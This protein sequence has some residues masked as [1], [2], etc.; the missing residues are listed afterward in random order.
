MR[1]PHQSITFNS[2]LNFPAAIAPPPPPPPPPSFALSMAIS[3]LPL[4]SY[5]PLICTKPSL[6]N[7]NNTNLNSSTLHISL[8][9]NP[10]HRA[11]TRLAKT[12]R[13]SWQNELKNA[14]QQPP[15]NQN[16]IENYSIDEIDKI[17]DESFQKLVDK[18]CVDNVRMLIV[19][20]VQNAKAG[21]P[22]M[23]MGMAEVGYYLYRHAMRYNP[24]N[25][26]WFNR[27]RFVL[28]A[29]HGC[30]LQYVCLHL[31]GFESVQVSANHKIYI[32]QFNF[33]V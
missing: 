26:K 13:L 27:D 32:S 6:N 8:R 19:D 31:A 28:S 23:A 10:P 2:R 33:S 3:S 15:S 11:T 21:H 20:A 17:D 12:H 5:F 18:K 7:K 4:K 9:T 1:L 16:L 25:P 14:F 30:L 29:G 22:G 24:R